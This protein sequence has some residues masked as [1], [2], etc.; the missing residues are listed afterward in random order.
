[1]YCLR[2]GTE[3][4]QDANFCYKCGTPVGKTGETSESTKWEYCEILY[5]Y[6]Y[7]KK[8][9]F[10]GEPTVTFLADAVGPTGSYTAAE[11]QSYKGGN[12]Y[13][14]VANN[15]KKE[16]ALADNAHKQL[17]QQLISEG[18]EATS[19]RGEYWWQLRFKRRVK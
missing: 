16:S 9:I 19:E 13:G 17:V 12:L 1:M 5:K 10:S 18:W 2:C 14:P 3:L 4:P 8:G 11:A 7:R 15:S 6:E